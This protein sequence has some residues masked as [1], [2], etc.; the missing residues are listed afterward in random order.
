MSD[1]ENTHGGNGDNE[2]D[3]HI[4]HRGH[5]SPIDSDHT[6]RHDHTIAGHVNHMPPAVHTITRTLV[7]H[8]PA[9]GRGWLAAAYLKHCQACDRGYAQAENCTVEAARRIAP[10]VVIVLGVRSTRD[11]IRPDREG[12][13]HFRAMAEMGMVKVEIQA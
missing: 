1:I 12:L 4:D 2:P 11:N 8:C 13:E 5:G 10:D 3:G 9:C 7:R 6:S